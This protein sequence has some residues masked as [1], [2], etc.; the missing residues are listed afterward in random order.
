MSRAQSNLRVLHYFAWQQG[1]LRFLCFHNE[2]CS[3]QQQAMWLESHT[4]MNVATLQPH[5][6]HRLWLPRSKECVFVLFLHPVKVWPSMK[7]QILWACCS[8]RVVNSFWQAPSSCHCHFGHIHPSSLSHFETISL[9][10]LK[11]RV[12]VCERHTRCKDFKDF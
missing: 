7:R 5:T 1:P 4:V 6:K 8:V 9:W 3:K 2:E 11:F 12:R 10:E